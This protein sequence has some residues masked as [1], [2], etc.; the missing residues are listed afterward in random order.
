[1]AAQWQTPSASHLVAFTVAG[2]LGTCGH[3]CLAWA[4]SRAH[5][6]RL[7]ILEYTAF[8]WGTLFGYLFFAET[9]TAATFG[10]AG[11]IVVACLMAAFTRPKRPG[12]APAREVEASVPSA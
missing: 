2:L 6:G 5:A 12:A 4:Y 10:G 7:G 11:L 1:M 8:L 3:L 9:P